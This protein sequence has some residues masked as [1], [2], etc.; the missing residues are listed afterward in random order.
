MRYDG[1]GG[2][3]RRG[4]GAP[5]PGEAKHTRL[6]T[7]RRDDEYGGQKICQDEGDGDGAAENAAEIRDMTRDGEGGQRC[8]YD[9]DMMMSGGPDGSTD[10]R[11]ADSD[12]RDRG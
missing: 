6:R 3:R 12:A 1:Y 8:W 4:V 10:G 5:L 9:R 2:S 11:A 7:R